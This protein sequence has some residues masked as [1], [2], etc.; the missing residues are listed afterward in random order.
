M[1]VVATDLAWIADLERE[2]QSLRVA[3][4]S[5]AKQQTSDAPIEPGGTNDFHGTVSAIVKLTQ[6][7]FPGPVSIELLADPESP[8]DAFVVLN[9]EASGDE[10]RLLERQCEWHER[11]AALTERDTIAFRLSIHPLP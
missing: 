2:V 11:I 5:L 1:K 6:Q 8:A 9:V 4:E 10:K 3:A 7:L